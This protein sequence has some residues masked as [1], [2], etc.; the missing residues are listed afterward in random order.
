M[1]KSD[2]MRASELRVSGICGQFVNQTGDVFEYNNL[3]HNFIRLITKFEVEP[4]EFA[5]VSAHY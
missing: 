1:D 2:E 3:P 4:A 5:V